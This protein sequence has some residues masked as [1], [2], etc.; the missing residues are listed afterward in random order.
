MDFPKMTKLVTTWQEAGHVNMTARH[1]DY[2]A[3][4]CFPTDGTHYV[5]VNRVLLLFK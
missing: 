5:L 4:R 1:R 2:T 3:S